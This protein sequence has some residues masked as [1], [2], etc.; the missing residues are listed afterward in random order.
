MREYLQ[1]NKSQLVLTLILLILTL[2]TYIVYQ[3]NKDN[4]LYYTSLILAESEGVEYELKIRNS[5]N[6]L[7][8]RINDNESILSKIP[9][10]GKPRLDVPDLSKVKAENTLIGKL[11]INELTWVLTFSDSF[12][13]IKYLIEY[14]NYEIEMYCSTSQYV[15]LF[16]KKDNIYKRLIVFRDTFMMSDMYEGAKLPSI[17]AYFENFSRL[18]ENIEGENNYE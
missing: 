13:Y 14:E 7:I 3:I 4:T 9:R 16:L 11:S 18:E 8:Y 15:E 2:S 5:D 10:V 1:R 6:A 12:K 17:T